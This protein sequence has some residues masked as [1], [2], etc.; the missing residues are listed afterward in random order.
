MTKRGVIRLAVQGVGLIGRRHVEHIVACP[1]AALHAVIDPSPVGG[2]IA[3]KHGVPWYP[4]FA[5][6]CAAGQP[7]GVVP[8]GV[9]I[10][11]PNQM[12]VENAL[13]CIAAGIPA[14]VEKPIADDIAAATVLVDTAERAGVPLLVGHHR[15][16][17]PMIQRAKAILDAGRLGRLVAV[18]GFFWLMKPDDYFDVPW[19]R[20]PGAGPVMTNLIHDI[21][22]LR[23][24][25]GEIETVQAMTSN[26]VRGHAV[27]ET[28]VILLR[29]ANGALGTV[30]VSDTVVA[31]W[32]WEHTTGENPAY[33]QTDQ[34]CYHLAGTHGALT[35][36][37]LDL[38]RN[39]AARGWWE[40]FQVERAYAPTQDPLQLQI[41][42][43]CAVIRGEVAPLVSGRE[44][45]R[46]LQVIAAV[47]QAS[48]SGGTVRLD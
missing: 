4:D 45:L 21:D 9:V 25:C 16:H 38:W 6:M 15:R 2:Q 41:K 36:P 19:R 28:A 43:F 44:G 5:A 11:T 34:S 26:A 18:H 10:A 20:A 39:P 35:V 12:H 17:N 13:A 33:P 32:S 37:K 47:Q 3:A 24:L 29:F 7:D 27:E 22:L 30:T 48:R 40:D 23:H 14:L 31:P 1:D 46:T 42:H 8:D